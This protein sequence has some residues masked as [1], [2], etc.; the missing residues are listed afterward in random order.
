ME[1]R[2]LVAILLSFLV[3]YAYQVFVQKP[4]M[5]KAKREAPVAAAAPGGAAGGAAQQAAIAAAPAA[6]VVLA[7]PL[8][9]DREER[10]IVVETRAL[11]AVFTNRG[12]R[13]K[14][15]Q[16]KTYLDL[17][18]KPQE[19]VATFLPDFLPVAT[20]SRFLNIKPSVLS[21]TLNPALS[22]ISFFL[23]WNPRLLRLN[24][25]AGR[26]KDALVKALVPA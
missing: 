8:V 19:L 10:D 24:P 21:P 17:Q 20:P 22:T 2:L 5:E 9:A 3:L 11:R 12:A 6:P 23:A 15:W 16:L 4:A 25:H 18:K 1:K 7:A 26:R 14:S 13:L